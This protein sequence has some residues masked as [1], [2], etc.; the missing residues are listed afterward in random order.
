MRNWFFPVRARVR[1]WLLEVD[2]H[3]IHTPFLYE[4]F[5][6]VVHVRPDFADFADIENYRSELLASEEVLN[7]NDL[8]SGSKHFTTA[9]RAISEIAATSPAAA[10]EGHF[11]YRLARFCKP[12]SILELGTSFGI[13]TLYLARAVAGRVHTIEGSETIAAL[14]NAQFRKLGQTNIRLHVGNIDDL[15]PNLLDQMPQVDLAVIDANHRYEPT[16]RYFEA[17]A[18]KSKSHTVIIL[19]DI[20]ASAEMEAAWNDVR[21]HELVYVD[22]DLFCCGLLFFDTAL[23]KQSLI[24]SL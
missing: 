16:V 1:H 19:H 22:I 21:R 7:V 23:Q 11:Y 5:S 3:S 4:L 10:H 17:L 8:G 18:R 20:H 24:A 13:S 15:L 12:K 6:T 2:E 14:A 9:L